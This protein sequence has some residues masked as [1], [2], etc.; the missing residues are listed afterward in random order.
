MRLFAK[1]NSL[2]EEIFDIKRN[3]CMVATFAM[4]AYLISTLHEMLCTFNAVAT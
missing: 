1:C 3:T 4:I 2:G